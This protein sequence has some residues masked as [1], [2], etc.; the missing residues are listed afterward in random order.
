MLI[1]LVKV[2]HLRQN[3]TSFVLYVIIYSSYTFYYYYYYQ[4]IL[5]K[6]ESRAFYIY[7]KNHVAFL[8]VQWPNE[9]D[10]EDPNV[11]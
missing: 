6:N 4:T 10:K 11:R 3:E 1:D 5:Y 7:I 9:D 8:I 2:V